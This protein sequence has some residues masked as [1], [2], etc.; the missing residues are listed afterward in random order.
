MLWWEREGGRGKGGEGRGER[1]GGEG[2]RRE[3]E[4]G[5]RGKGREEDHK[6][7]PSIQ[8]LLHHVYLEERLAFCALVHQSF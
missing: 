8:G 4:G 7:A 3:R 2:G 6:K 1:E 5:E